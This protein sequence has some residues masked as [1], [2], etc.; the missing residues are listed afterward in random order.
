MVGDFSVCWK[1]SSAAVMLEA[2]YLSIRDYYDEDAQL[3]EIP[4]V[5]LD[6]TTASLWRL[7]EL[8][9]R[10]RIAARM[11]QAACEDLVIEV[12]PVSRTTVGIKIFQPIRDA[13]VQ[14]QYL[15]VASGSSA[16][17][18]RTPVDGTIELQNLTSSQHY[19]IRARYLSARLGIQCRWSSIHKVK[20]TSE[21]PPAIPR[22]VRVAVQGEKLVMHWRVPEDDG[23]R[24]I[25]RFVIM[26]SEASSG[27]FETALVLTASDLYTAELTNMRPGVQYLL[28]IAASNAIGL[29]KFSAPITAPILEK[30]VSVPIGGIFSPYHHLS[31]SMHEPAELTQAEARILSSKNDSRFGL[32]SDTKEVLEVDGKAIHGWAGHF[33]PK[34]YDVHAPLYF[35]DKGSC[36]ALGESGA[37]GRILVVERGGCPLY[38]KASHAAAVGAMAIVFVT[39]D[40]DNSCIGSSKRHGDGFAST[41]DSRLWKKLHL[42]ALMI[43]RKH[44]DLFSIFPHS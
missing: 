39:D 24:D 41:D 32:L 38:T 44:L 42:P 1:S 28:K 16:C 35:D 36:D 10:L 33:S 34:L 2:S 37:R 7:R 11:R 29:G 40:D 22:D 15:N 23:G 4:E 17:V 6:E 14:V 30:K 26:R 21:G 18:T 20:L 25:E 8:Q 27:P 13:L 9:M 12:G 5:K 19:A 31:P 3:Q 43:Q